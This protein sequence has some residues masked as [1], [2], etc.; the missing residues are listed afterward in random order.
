MYEEAEEAFVQ[1][2]RAMSEVPTLGL[3]DF[4]KPF[5]LEMDASNI[6]V[7]A[8]LLGGQAIGFH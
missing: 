6:G 4:S 2:K 5:T 8:V 1:L 3:L 7:G